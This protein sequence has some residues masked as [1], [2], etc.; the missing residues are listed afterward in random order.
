MNAL[1]TVCLIF[2]AHNFRVKLSVLV[3]L[4]LSLVTLSVHAEHEAVRREV[5]SGIRKLPCSLVVRQSCRG[6]EAS[7]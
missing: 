4:L 1:F 2:V 3:T 5:Q 7:S 6:A